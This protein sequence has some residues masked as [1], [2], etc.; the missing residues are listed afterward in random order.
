M[1][2]RGE[3]RSIVGR[4]F[5]Y[6]QWTQDVDGPECWLSAF[7][8]LYRCSEEAGSMAVPLTVAREAGCVSK[9]DAKPEAPAVRPQALQVTAN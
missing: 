5:F 8:C 6:S 9:C 3:P 1:R 4:V 7:L 2:L